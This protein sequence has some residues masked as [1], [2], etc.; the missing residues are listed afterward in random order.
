MEWDMEKII[1]AIYCVTSLTFLF[2]LM[3]NPEA[4]NRWPFK[5]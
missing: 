5:K 1:L 3:I 2:Y 4:F